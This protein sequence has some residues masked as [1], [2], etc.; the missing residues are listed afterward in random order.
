MAL[1]MKGKLMALNAVL[2]DAEEK[3]ITNPAV[4]AWPDELKDAVFDAEDLLDEINTDSLRIKMEGESKTFTTQVTSFLSSPFNQFYKNMNFKLEAISTKLEDFLKEKDILGLK[5]VSRRVSYRT[6]TDS[7]VESVVVAREDDKDN[8]LSMLLS[9]EDENNN[10]IKVLTIWDC[11]KFRGK[12]P[13]HLPSLVELSI[14]NC[15]Q[16]EAKSCDLKWKT[17]IE[18]IYISGV[19]EGLLSLLDNFSCRNLRISL[20]DNFSYL[21]RMIPYVNCLQKLI[22][23]CVPNLISFPI[24]GLP[25]S[26]QSLDISYCKNLEFMS[27]ESWK[28][29]TSLE[30]LDILS[31]CH[32]LKSFPLD[33]FPTLQSLSIKDCCSMEAITTQSDTTILKLVNLTVCNCENLRSF[34]EQIYLPA[35][36]LLHLS[37]LPKVASLSPKCL[38]SSLQ[39][40]VVDVGKL[41][42]MSKNDLDFLFQRLTSLSTLQINGF[43]DEDFVNTLMKEP[44]LPT[45]LQHL[46]ISQFNGLKCLE[47]EGKG[48]QHLTSLRSLFLSDSPGLKLLKGNGLQHLTFLRNL[49]IRDCRT[50]ESLP[51]DQL[52]SSLELLQIHNCPFLKEKYQIQKGKYWSKIAHIPAIEMNGEVII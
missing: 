38:P 13:S 7:L 49:L 40:L 21:P 30:S 16:L 33:C 24:D 31:S 50:L 28:K 1:A 22:L 4:K 26:L 41:S 51:E 20:W 35:L 5:S 6:V 36:E 39:E 8:L 12:L 48:L 44:L 34:P 15:N 11:P 9:D 3:Q 43:G 46:E 18:S 27:A 14:W 42:C 10:N 45:S 52:P 47:V 37:K 2:N 19:G 23:H 32:S 29:C 17:S 25:T